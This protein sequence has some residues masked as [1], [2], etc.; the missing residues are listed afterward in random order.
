MSKKY[1][2]S[3]EVSVE[4]TW[5][6]YGILTESPGGNLDDMPGDDIFSN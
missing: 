1:Y 6:L 5:P 4:S 2:V 3:P